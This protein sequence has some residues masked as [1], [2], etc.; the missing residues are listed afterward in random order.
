MKTEC[1][2]RWPLAIGLLAIGVL[3]VG[4]AVYGVAPPTVTQVTPAPQPASDDAAAQPAAVASEAR[5]LVS[6]A[7]GMVSEVRAV[8]LWG[9]ASPEK[10]VPGETGGGGMRE[11]GVCDVPSTPE[12]E[13]T[14]Y[15][16]YDDLFNSGCNAPAGPYPFSTILCDTTV[17]G[18]AGTH[19]DGSGA[20][21]EVLG[22]AMAHA[23]PASAVA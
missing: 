17:C 5:A 15:D 23:T 3:V 2:C 6:E 1:S 11:C 8:E 13:E 4:P 19:T 12:G 22:F 14:C 18:E 20:S 10:A 7:R 9:A 21:L 16:G